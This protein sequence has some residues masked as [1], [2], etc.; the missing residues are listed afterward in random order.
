MMR[1]FV[2]EV[3]LLLLVMRPAL[4]LW[5]LILAVERDED[6]E[7]EDVQPWTTMKAWRKTRR[8]RS[9]VGERLGGGMMMEIVGVSYGSNLLHAV[10]PS[11]LYLACG[12]EGHGAAAV[13]PVKVAIGKVLVS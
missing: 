2:G 3:V 12:V 8:R 4:L 11:F 10:V 13:V 7:G 1:M 5:C 6:D 9:T